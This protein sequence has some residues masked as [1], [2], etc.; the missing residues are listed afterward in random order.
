MRIY[1]TNEI[2]NF[3]LLGNAGSGKTT[4][5]EAMLFEG[6]VITRRGEV[7]A[8][9]TVSDYREIEQAQGNSVFSSV[10][11]TETN[12]KK[13]NFID[14]PG[15]DDFCGNVFTALNVMDTAVMLLNAQNGVEVGSEIQWRYI[16]KFN[17]PT[18]FVVNHLDHEKANFDKAIEE[19][20]N[21]FG[22]KVLLAQYPV[23]AGTGFNAIIDVIKMK[24][25]K[26]GTDGGKAQILDIPASEMAHAERIQSALIEAAA[27]SDETL[28]ETFFENGTLTD[29]EMARGMK[30]GIISRNLFPVFCI[31]AK[32]N[33]GVDRFMEFVC[34]SLPTPIELPSLQT[35]DGE[36]VAYD[37]KGP[38]SLFVFKNSVEQHIGEVLYFKVM[39]GEL[40]ESADL[41]NMNKQSKERLSQL[42]V[43]AGKNRQKINKFVLGDIGATVKLKDT[44]A[45]QTLNAKNAEWIFSTCLYPDPKHRVAVV[46]LN[47]ADEEKVSEALIRMHDEDP[48]LVVEYSKELKQMLLHGQGEY[49]LNTVKWHLDNIY[50]IAVEYKM[51]RISYR[52]TITKTAATSYRHK[53]QSGGSGQFGEVHIYMEP[54]EEGKPDPT[55]FKNHDKE[56]NLSVRGKEEID[57]EWGGKLVYYNCIVGGVIEA[58]FMPAI[59][60]GILEKMETG[61]LTGSYARDIRVAVYDGKMHPVDSNEISFKLA[62]MN[63]FKNAFKEAGPKI[64]E[65]IYEVEILVPSDRMGDVM[66]D[67]QTRRALIMGMQSE[68]GY[69]KLSARIPLAEMYKYCTVLSSLTSGRATFTMRFAEYVQ[70]PSEIQDQ[71]LKAYEAE[72]KD[73]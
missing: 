21:L 7:T 61:P 30:A 2:R 27:E 4:F 56:T 50:K 44:K 18:M 51:P 54:W 67:L 36:E 48:T 32:K 43:C 41:I 34:D 70:V 55:K 20:K 24:M 65:P 37:A 33:I 28:M 10:M 35:V 26:Y 31:S 16:K 69:E 15:L 3:A 12:N 47:E 6:G 19:A 14:C 53:K 59:L 71:L 39:S 72:Q 68:S 73:E 63:A 64:M 22:S 46:A 52:E 66:S 17:K 5:T 57:M 60:K 38:I 62:G 13:L 1:Q 45:N 49:H 8:K 29:E 9:S 40:E 58:R 23:N 25:Y 42:Y 11:Y